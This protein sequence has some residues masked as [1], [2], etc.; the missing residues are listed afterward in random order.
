MDHILNIQ[1]IRGWYSG[2]YPMIIAGPCSA[3]DEKQ[4]M[5]TALALAE[6]KEVGIFRAGIWKPRT[7]PSGF[8]GVSTKGLKWLHRVKRDTGLMTAVEIGQAD[9]VR[10][11]LDHSIDIIWIGARTVVNPFSMQEIAEVL[12]N[13]DMPV[14]IKNPVNPDPELWIGAIERINQAGVTKLIAVHRGF[15]SPAASPYRNEPMWEIPIE[16]KRQYPDLPLICDPSH[17]SGRR[18]LIHGISQRALD[19]GME[20]L[21]IES[22]ISPEMALTDSEQQIE[23]EEVKKL[24]EQLRFPKSVGAQSFEDELDGL[25]TAIDQV[26]ADL[27]NILSKR[28]DIVERI[29]RI[30]Q[31]H[32][33]AAFQ[34]KR[35]QEVRARF[36]KSGSLAGLDKKFLQELLELLHKESIRIQ[37][38]LFSEDSGDQQA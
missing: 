14:F 1:A 30:K 35:W 28:M 15:F 32:N 5:E 36:I 26:D 16:I 2:K 6:I 22:H 23:P 20:G 11:C 9:H 19:L 29:G 10:A 13:T 18:E 8:E 24:M 37:T 17:I 21:M 27:I 12:Q 38:N 34:V 7:R 31:K 25:R 3:E 4:V 33:M